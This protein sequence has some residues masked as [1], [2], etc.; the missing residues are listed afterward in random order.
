MLKLKFRPLDYESG[1]LTTWATYGNKEDSWMPCYFDG[2]QKLFNLIRH[3]I[4]CMFGL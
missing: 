1:V 3:I 4:N 2:I